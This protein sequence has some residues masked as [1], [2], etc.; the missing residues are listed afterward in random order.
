MIDTGMAMAAMMRRPDVGEEEEDDDRGEQAAEHQ[1]MLERAHGGLDE[2]RLVIDA[3]RVLTSGGR[4]GAIS[5]S[6]ALTVCATVDRVL[7]RTASRRRA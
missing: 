3:R 2:D 7:A 1:V 5:A 4:V 6:R